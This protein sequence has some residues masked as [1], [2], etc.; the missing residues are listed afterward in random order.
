MVSTAP[1]YR[2]GQREEPHRWSI[3]RASS[4]AEERSINLGG[5]PR[6][7]EDPEAQRRA[8]ACPDSHSELDTDQG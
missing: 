5:G 4:S 1:A 2:G 7:N 3:R 8:V 6:N